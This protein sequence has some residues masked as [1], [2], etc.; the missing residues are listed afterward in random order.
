M[1]FRALPLMEKTLSTRMMSRMSPAT[2]DGAATAQIRARVEPVGGVV[3]PKHLAEVRVEKDTGSHAPS[4]AQGGKVVLAEPRGADPVVMVA[5][6]ERRV[7][8]CGVETAA[9]EAPVAAPLVAAGRAG[10]T[11]IFRPVP[12]HLGQGR[13]S[14]ARVP[15]SRAVRYVASLP[16]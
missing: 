8:V 4:Q 5:M 7:Q 13:C 3:L 9:A 12:A 10:E 1:G 6:V 11:L 16:P 14:G 15:Q 2:A